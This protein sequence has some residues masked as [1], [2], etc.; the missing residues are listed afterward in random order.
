MN[1]FMKE[2]E[3][4]LVVMTVLFSFHCAQDKWE[5]EIYTQGDVKIVENKG[6]GLWEGDEG[7]NIS[8]EE[9]LSLG[10]EQGEDHLMFYRLGDLTVD[11]DLNLYI[12]DAGNHRII[13]FDKQGQFLWK[14]GRKGQ[15]PGE[16]QYPRSITLS[17][18]DEVVVGDGRRVHFFTK[19][20]EYLRSIRIDKSYHDF[21]FLP[22]GRLL[23]TIFVRGRPGV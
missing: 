9:G 13:K 5:G 6:A 20:G 16:F 10:Q 18:E 4:V 22:D 12:L 8:F 2:M 15:G 21:Y 1:T 7:K 19:Q 14:A 11:S 23:V 17:P 3:C